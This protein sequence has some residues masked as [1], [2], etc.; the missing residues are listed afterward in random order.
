MYRNV[1]M[2]FSCFCYKYIVKKYTKYLK[3][4][5]AGFCGKDNLKGRLL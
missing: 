4:N 2:R 3:K 5:I 1:A